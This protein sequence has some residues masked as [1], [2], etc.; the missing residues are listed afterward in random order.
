MIKEKLSLFSTKRE[1]FTFILACGFILTYSLL[2]EYNNY[3][4][5]T[6]FD[7]NIINA[8]IIKQY[9]K[10]KLTKNNKLKT[11]QVLKLKA[12]SGFTFYTTK[13][14]KFPYLKGSKIKLELYYGD[15]SFYQYMSSFFS[16]S[17]T[18]YIYKTKTIKQ[19]LNSF[20]SSQHKDKN[21]SDI[22]QALFSAS[23]PPS[24]L[25]QILSNLGISHLLAISGFH[26]GVL[27]TLLYFLF[28]TPYQFL[29]NRYFPYRSYKLDSFVLITT[30]LLVYLIF[31]DFPDSLL[32]AFVMLV[33]GFILYDRGYKIVSMW[34]L[35]LTAILI[36]SFFPRLLFSLGFWL[37]I[38]GVFYIFLFMKY[39]KDLNKIWQFIMIPFWVYLLMLPI[40]LFIFGSFSIYHPLSIIWTTLF[41]IFY[42]LSIVLHLFGFGYLFDEI[43][44][45]LIYLDIDSKNISLSW[46]VGILYLIISYLGVFKKSFLYLLLIFALSIFIYSV[47][48]VA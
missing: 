35:F 38:S 16:F 30:A 7:S 14:K 41:T 42:P 15:I 24:D 36:I 13:S 29:Q 33:I 39:F 12:D 18:I 20:I 23:S 3:K 28:K 4:N 22:Y 44:S 21:I 6:R 40:S 9:K 48:N 2:I 10:T 11:Y 5:L 37:S 25:Q 31:L 46:H 34:T 32:R 26:L 19:K 27:S 17:R 43:L 1:F 47:Y 45:N 8:T